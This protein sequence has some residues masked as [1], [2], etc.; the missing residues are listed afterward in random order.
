[1]GSASKY[2]TI[3][4]KVRDYSMKTKR[5]LKI[6]VTTLAVTSLLLVWSRSQIV[7]AAA[8]IVVDST[9]DNTTSGDGEC[10][11]REAINNANS[12]SGDTT[13]GDCV[14]GTGSGGNTIDFNI[15]HTSVGD[16]F[17]NQGFTGYTIKPGSALPNI[18][19]TVTIN[20][21]S[22]PN[23]QPNTG[24]SPNPLNGILLIEIDGTNAGGS[25]GFT[26]S[27][28]SDASILKGIIAN[29]F[30]ICGIAIHATNINI[31]GNYLGTDPTGLIAR[32]NWCGV[33]GNSDP[34][35]LGTHVLVGGTQP[36]ERNLISGNG[37]SGIY[38]SNNWVIQG[39]YIGTDSTGIHALGN[40]QINSGGIS[41]DN[42]DTVLVGGDV[43][44][45]TNVISGNYL[46]G[47]SPAEATN[48][49]IQGNYVGVDA[50]GLKSLG[51][52]S[53][54]VFPGGTTNVLIGGTTALARNIISG[55]TYVDVAVFGSPHTT[56]EGNF[57][58]VDK[59]GNIN[60]QI[61]AAGT[62]VLVL[63]GEQDGQLIGGTDPSSANIIAGHTSYGVVIEET[64]SAPGFIP[65]GVS[66][67][68]NSI[69]DNGGIG[70]ELARDMNGDFVPD[71]ETGTN[72]NVPAG[73]TPGK[74]NDYVN[75]PVLNSF[76]QSGTQAS[77]DLDLN[78]AG[79]TRGYRVE[80]F[81]NDTN[82]GGQGKQFLGYVDVENGNNQVKTFTMPLGTNL[83]GKYV[84]ATLTQLIDL[85]TDNGFGSTSEFSDTSVAAKVLAV[86]TIG[87][88]NTG[89]GGTASIGATTLL[90][91]FG[92]AVAMILVAIRLKKRYGP[93]K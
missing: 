66:V 63:A 42:A 78:V 17:T 15:T 1:M 9:A 34:S 8:P 16:T 20:G 69:F 4:L 10:T 32:S 25:N 87:A 43:P 21:Y 89:L 22:E 53:F 79:G 81:A 18:T 3:P 57:I 83:T 39:N 36:N 11:L 70:I 72:S 88:P 50:T 56:V 59:N 85:G 37:T 23:A 92:S 58:G 71:T 47:I 5:Y 55:N 26:L 19:S 46:Y 65:S 48:V 67:L 40:G 84:T 51:N 41:I 49:T 64:A 75:H 44:G 27:P 80:F 13:G 30:T 28:G 93:S 76:T 12:T 91:Y 73:S 6:V 31:Q 52:G 24:V 7:H 2:D 33:T 74:P 35:H 45:S 82:S 14:I 77:V 61:V 29:N 38:P 68:G 90:E 60:S 54:G 62:G 86:N